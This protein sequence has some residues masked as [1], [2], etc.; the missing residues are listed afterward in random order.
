MVVLHSTIVDGKLH[1]IGFVQSG[2]PGA[3]GA[4]IAW[5]DTSGGIGAW[6]LKIRNASDTGWESVSGTGG[7]SSG[8]FIPLLMAEPTDVSLAN[9]T[10]AF[11]YDA[12]A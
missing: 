3:V 12:G 10:A 1:T 5:V 9:E 4:S 6:V 8:N 7:G 2:D 11:W